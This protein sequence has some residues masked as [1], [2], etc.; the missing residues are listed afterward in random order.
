MENRVESF[1]NIDKIK[2]NST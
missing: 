1:L 2:S